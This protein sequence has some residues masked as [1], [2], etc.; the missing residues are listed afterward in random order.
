MLIRGLYR[1][2]RRRPRF[3]LYYMPAFHLKQVLSE[4]IRRSLTESTIDYQFQRHCEAAEYGRLCASY[5]GQTYKH[6]MD[7]Y[8]DYHRPTCYLAWN[9]ET[10]WRNE[11]PFAFPTMSAEVF[12]A[13]ALVL[14]DPAE[15]LTRFLDIPWCKADLFYIR[16]LVFAIEAHG[17]VLWQD[18]NTRSGKAG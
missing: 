12:A 10:M 3:F 7:A 4:G 14:R 8:V 2:V 5:A 18:V 16:K 13:R 15:K 11:C 9:V 17:K 1:L 6:L